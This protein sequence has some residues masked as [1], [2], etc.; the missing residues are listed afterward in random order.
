MSEVG[1]RGAREAQV[2][3]TP[4]E[5]NVGIGDGVGEVLD[6]VAVAGQ[7]DQPMAQLGELATRGGQ[8]L[9]PRAHTPMRC[10]S[11]SRFGL[12]ALV[13]VVAGGRVRGVGKEA[14][15]RVYRRRHPRR[16]R[17]ARLW[18]RS[19]P[20]SRSQSGVGRVARGQTYLLGRLCERPGQVVFPLGAGVAPSAGFEPAHTA[21]EA[22]ALCNKEA[23]QITRRREDGSQHL[24]ARSFDEDAAESPTGGPRRSP[25]RRSAGRRRDRR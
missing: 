2:V 3:A 24:T 13:Q 18:S 10:V 14:P 23:G 20:A 17:G 7:L 1:P 21:P 5:A 25:P 6:R 19:G 4:A 12:V 8:G 11:G 16:P 9:S 15:P 22:D